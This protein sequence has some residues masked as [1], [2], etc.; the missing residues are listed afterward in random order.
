MTYADLHTLIEGQVT[1]SSLAF[2]H[3][4]NDHINT[5]RGTFPLAVLDPPT[6]NLEG[7]G[8]PFSAVY[9]IQMAFMNT[10]SA[11]TDWS[12]RRAVVEAMDAKAREF[13]QRLDR[14]SDLTPIT[15]VSI[16]PFFTFPFSSHLTAG[17]LL[18]FVDRD[19][20]T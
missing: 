17:V 11:D 2:L 20:E 1:A 7:G 12:V 19:W 4:E 5:Y 8:W 13:I 16:Q 14:T 10:I 6:A 18:T 9:L 3:S 15:D